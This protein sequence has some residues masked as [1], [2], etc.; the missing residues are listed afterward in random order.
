MLP[1]VGFRTHTDT[2]NAGTELVHTYV[3]LH[4]TSALSGTSVDPKWLRK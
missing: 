1:V 2:L 3:A 4:L